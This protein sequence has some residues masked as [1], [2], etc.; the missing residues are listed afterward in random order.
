LHFI[1]EICLYHHR[2]AFEQSIDVVA[3]IE[4]LHK[5]VSFLAHFDHIAG[6]GGE[7]VAHGADFDLLVQGGFGDEVFLVYFADR[8]VAFEHAH[9]RFEFAL[10]PVHVVA[11]AFGFVVF[12]S[13]LSDFEGEK[14]VV[15]VALREHARFYED[16]FV[17]FGIQVCFQGIVPLFAILAFLVLPVLKAVVEFILDFR[18]KSEGGLTTWG[19]NFHSGIWAKVSLPSSVRK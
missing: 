6:G 7:F 10:L 4:S 5:C 18:V 11:F 12:V 17:G 9:L 13:F 2:P 15:D 19:R 1:V 14:F 8:L 16:L 3:L